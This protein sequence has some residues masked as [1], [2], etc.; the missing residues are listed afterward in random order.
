MKKFVLLIVFFT[1]N[2]VHSKGFIEPQFNYEMNSFTFNSTSNGTENTYLVPSTGYGFGAKLGYV[3]KTIFFYLQG[4]YSL[5]TGGDYTENSVSTVTGGKANYLKAGLG[6]GFKLAKWFRFYGGMD[7]IDQLT[8]SENWTSSSGINRFNSG[9][10][11]KG[12]NI[13]FGL[14]FIFFKKLA[15]NFQYNIVAYTQTTYQGTAYSGIPS[16]WDLTSSAIV[17]GIS[18]PLGFNKK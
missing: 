5:V 16:N 15:I 9:D 11:F 1:I 14:S 8:I 18:I 4:S 17:G 6:I 13:N 12:N 10:F 7:I 3:G 2:V